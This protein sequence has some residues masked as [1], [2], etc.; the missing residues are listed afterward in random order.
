MPSYFLAYSTLKNKKSAG[1]IE[2]TIDNI[3]YL[4][5]DEVKLIT[6]EHFNHIANKNYESIYA[7]MKNPL[8][9]EEELVI[10]KE[11]TNNHF[12]IS[13]IIIVDKIIEKKIEVQLHSEIFEDVREDI[14]IL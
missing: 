14:I 12:D 2:Y 10:R 8:L 5:R 3:Y 4:N 11:L 6:L 7:L 9:F 1:Q 13:A